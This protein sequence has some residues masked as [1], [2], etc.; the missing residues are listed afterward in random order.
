MIDSDDD[1]G[2]DDND[3]SSAASLDPDTIATGAAA[4]SAAD[5]DD[6]LKG[7]PRILRYAMLVNDRTDG[8][9]AQRLIAEI[10][11]LCPDLPANIA[12]AADPAA[13]TGLALAAELDQLAVLRDLPLLRTLGDCAR[14]LSLSL[15]CDAGRLG[16]FRRVTR[17]M[18]IAF[19]DCADDLVE[20]QRCDLER[21]IAGWAALPTA[22]DAT[23]VWP[24]VNFAA[25]L[26]D[27]MARYRIRSAAADAARRVRRDLDP[28]PDATRGPDAATSTPARTAPRS[29]PAEPAPATPLPP[30]HVVVGRLNQVEG[31]SA[32]LKGIVEP[33]KDVL[34]IPL[35]L[36]ET[37]ALDRV[38]STLVAEFPHA[39]AVINV[40]LA[41]LIGRPVIRLRPL[42][43]VGEPGGGKSHFVRRL[44]EV[45][46]LSIWRVDAAQSD[47]AVLG[48]TDRRW[49][50]AECCHP[51]LAIARGRSANPVILLDE[52]EKA[53]TRTD[54]GRLWDC[55]LGLLEPETSSRYPDPALQIP[56]D[57]SHVNY[58]ATAN[59]LE[60]LPAP[61]RDRFRIVTFPKPTV[62]DL[63][64]LL[65]GLFKT[66]A[67]ERG[68]DARWIAPLAADERNA[69]ASAWPG[70]SVRRLLRI[71][72]AVLQARDRHA[73]RQ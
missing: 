14:L 23:G 51:L 46:G 54:Y 29:G 67:A 27:Q 25:R 56:L 15:P 43:L 34:N 13:T 41:D 53:G 7:L 10:D 42:L 47:G 35:P 48:G 1:H 19:D 5:A 31:G 11:E 36:I 63:D 3:E 38:R 65:P 16:D 22:A 73:T 68:I 52:L 12:W 32:K 18:R 24:A 6:R 17:A 71:L 28:Q 64:A 30:H 20:E 58:L 60:P 4:D 57:L 37:P 9:I 2:F 66:L 40:A 21:F 33:V 62:A 69:I 44:G 45:L 39:A 50:S 70:G 59:S 26:G 55:L 72:D 8:S 49:H 61:L